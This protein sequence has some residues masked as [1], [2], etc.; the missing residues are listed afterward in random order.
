MKILVLNGPNLNL[1]GQREPD[2]YGVSTL[3][4]IESM[5][6]D[7]GRDIGVELGFAQSNH[8]GAL[9]DAIQGAPGTYDGIV[10][11]AGAYTHSSIAI[12]DAISATTLPVLELHLSNVHAREGFRHHSMIAPVC[13]GVIGGFGATGYL[14]ALRAMANHLGADR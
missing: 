7:T 9:V 12:R 5:C 11:N 6:L 13:I 8:E 1:L 3:A 10:L 14:L 2:I 4:D